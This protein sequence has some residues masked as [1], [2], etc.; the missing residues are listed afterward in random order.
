[1]EATRWAASK[2]VD[3]GRW[4]VKHIILLIVSDIERKLLC[5]VVLLFAVGLPVSASSNA[6]ALDADFQKLTALRIQVLHGGASESDLVAFRAVRD[7]FVRHGD[8]AAEF[9]IGK[10]REMNNE[11]ATYEKDLNDVEGGLRY[12]GDQV[13]HHKGGLAKYDICFILADAFPKV[14][15]QT[16]SD[17]LNALQQSYRPSNYGRDDMQFLHYAMWRIGKRAVPVLLRLSVEH[18]ASLVRCGVSS[19]LNSALE[20]IE[21]KNPQ[22]KE[23][24]PTLDCTARSYRQAV[25]HW[26]RWW[27][28]YGRDVVFEPLPS[29]YDMSR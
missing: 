17:I 24:P 5:S 3:P 4:Q 27:E 13:D 14:S 1:M 22:L 26:K 28:R 7:S 18:P 19:G 21:T 12:L 10:L 8:A 20:Q 11:E 29:F 15:S 23:L 6:D 2:I 16:Q 9:L 25:E